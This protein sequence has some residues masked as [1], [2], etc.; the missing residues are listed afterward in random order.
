MSSTLNISPDP[1][2]LIVLASTPL[3][4][5]DALC[6][7]IDN[8]LDSFVA[9]RRAGFPIESRW[10][11]ITI[12][13]PSQIENGEGVVRVVDNGIG[14]DKEGLEGALKAGFSTK[15]KYDQ[16]GLFGVGFNI[17]TAKLGQKTTVTTAKPDSTG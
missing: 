10:V 12:P 9:A 3:K 6:E 11:R 13:K 2:I 5:I 15:N 14:L 8:A 7:L 4:P 16:L 1:N 17:A